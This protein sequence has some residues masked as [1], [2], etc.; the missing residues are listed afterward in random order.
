MRAIEFSLIIGSNDVVMISQ[1]I[2]QFRGIFENFRTQM[3]GNL[4]RFLFGGSATRSFAVSD[5]N[6]LVIREQCE[7][8]T[9][10][11]A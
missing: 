4:Y 5:D 1:V 7:I 3:A 11:F 9:A 6:V 2:I 10:E 8:L